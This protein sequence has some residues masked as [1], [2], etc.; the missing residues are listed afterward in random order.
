MGIRKTETIVINDY[1][2]YWIE[3]TKLGHIIKICYGPNDIRMDIDCRWRNRER[4]TNGH[5][6]DKKNKSK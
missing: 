1:K 4:G 5:P 2:K 3:E 6:E